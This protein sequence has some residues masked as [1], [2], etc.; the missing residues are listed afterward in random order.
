M[1]TLLSILH[2]ILGLLFILFIIFNSFNI[3]IPIIDFLVALI[4]I[5]FILFNKCIHLD[6]YDFIKNQ[7]NIDI[8][9]QYNNQEENGNDYPEYTRD[10]YFFSKLQ[11]M[12]F[13][14]EIISK[15][16]HSY[17]LYDAK[18]IE[19]LCNSDDPEIIKTIFNEKIHY[20]VSSCIITV[21]LLTKYKLQK[22]IPIFIIWFYL[23]FPQ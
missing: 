20:I 3:N 17:K 4:P 19:P 12:L 7:S 16:T 14:E 8:E 9:C 13:G 18:D 22:L 10:G 5:S 1:L 2:T 15:R 23:T 21:I 11:Q 6:F